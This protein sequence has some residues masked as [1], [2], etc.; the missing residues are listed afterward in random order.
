MQIDIFLLSALSDY[1][2]SAHFDI[3][4]RRHAHNA[5]SYFIGFQIHNS[6]YYRNT[7]AEITTPLSTTDYI[8]LIYHA[9][10][11]RR[12]YYDTIARRIV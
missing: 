2:L 8:V 10:R 11:Y 1:G 6:T 5:E 4:T 9:I 7:Y 3:R 12:V